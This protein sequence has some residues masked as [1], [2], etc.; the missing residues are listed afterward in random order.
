LFSLRDQLV[1]TSTTH[2][3]VDQYRISHKTISHQVAAATM[4]FVVSAP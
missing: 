4:K 1:Q 3:S 2:S